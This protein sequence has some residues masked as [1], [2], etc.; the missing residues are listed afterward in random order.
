MPQFVNVCIYGKVKVREFIFL[1]A[2]VIS[3]ASKEKG[4]ACF[5]MA[6]FYLEVRVVSEV[7]DREENRYCALR[8]KFISVYIY[9]IYL[10]GEFIYLCITP[11][12]GTES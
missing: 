1:V 3:L 10:D 12:G 2:R 9:L 8:Y 6:M 7:E 4:R 11:A 5:A